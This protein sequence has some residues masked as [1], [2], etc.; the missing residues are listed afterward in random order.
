[1]GV[2][3]VIIVPGDGANFPAQGQKITIHYTGK[4]DD[5]SV[6]DS[7]VAKGA[8]FRFQVGMGAVIRGA[9]K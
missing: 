8:P 9:R 4:L 7:S 2:T 6:F 3:K 5:G 1:M